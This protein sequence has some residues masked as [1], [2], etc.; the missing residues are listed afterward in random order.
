MFRWNL[1]YFNLCLVLFICMG[2]FCLLFTFSRYQREEF[3]SDLF[4]PS[5]QIFITL[6]R[7]PWIFSTTGWIASALS[8]SLPIIEVLILQPSQWLFAVL[9]LVT[10]YLFLTGK[11]SN[12][13][14]SVFLMW[15]NKQPIPVPDHPLNKDQI[16]I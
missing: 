11:P 9:S 13:L 12:V 4:T 6:I 1:F 15:L 7:S 3:G 8:A 5:H 16:F 10:L 14:N 2:V